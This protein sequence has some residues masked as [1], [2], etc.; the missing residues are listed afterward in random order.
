[1]HVNFLPLWDTNV[2]CMGK[3]KSLHRSNLFQL[4]KD[5]R[6]RGARGARG[7]KLPRQDT[8]LIIWFYPEDVEAHKAP[9]VLSFDGLYKI[10]PTQATYLW[11]DF[12]KQVQLIP[13]SLGFQL[14]SE[15]M[16]YMI[17]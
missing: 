4:H 8:N 9:A 2:L 13:K 17:W 12:Q 5:K 16:M 3:K 1:M 14:I 7:E 10:C 6:Y 11:Y 15:M